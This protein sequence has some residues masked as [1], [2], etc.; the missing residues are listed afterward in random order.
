MYINHPAGVEPPSR[1]NLDALHPLGT[2]VPSPCRAREEPYAIPI[3]YANELGSVA[4]GEYRYRTAKK[5]LWNS[6]K[7]RWHGW[8]RN[9]VKRQYR[10]QLSGFRRLRKERQRERPHRG[11]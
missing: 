8:I 5:R 6:R 11:R 7:G 4:L 3:R 10:V 1:T 2:H 9:L